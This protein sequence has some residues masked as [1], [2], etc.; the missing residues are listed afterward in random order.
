MNS[1]KKMRE[2]RGLSQRDLAARIGLS[3]S[4]V[5]RLET[6]R[7]RLT[8]EVA[9]EIARILSVSVA[10]VLNDSE[11]GVSF[12][13]HH[14]DVM[15]TIGIDRWSSQAVKLEVMDR[16][17]VLSRGKHNDL[18]H[19]AYKM[20]DD[21]A[22][23]LTRAGGYVVMVPYPAA[24]KTAADGEWV[25]ARQSEGR[26]SRLI[27]CRT[28]RDPIEKYTLDTPEGSIPAGDDIE[29]IGLIVATYSSIE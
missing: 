3:D 28:K 7:R 16:I 22:L 1:V 25:I 9:Q 4:A 27:V 14:I 24:R 15:G 26:V 29:I 12:R 8:V 5:S 21:H 6:G 10:D 19:T 13:E 18:T 17:P 11:D 2:F 23:P 20:E